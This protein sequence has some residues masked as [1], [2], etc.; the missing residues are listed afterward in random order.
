MY[1]R[2][3]ETPCLWHLWK[4]FFKMRKDL[5][6]ISWKAWKQAIT[7]QH[8]NTP[9]FWRFH[10]AFRNPQPDGYPLD[11]GNKGFRCAEWSPQRWGVLKCWV[12]IACFYAFQQ[13]NTKFFL[14]FV[15]NF[16][17][18]KMYVIC[19]Y[20]CVYVHHAYGVWVAFCCACWVSVPSLPALLSLFSQDGKTLA[21]ELE[22][23]EGMQFERG[24]ISPYFINSPKG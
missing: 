7:T 11:L 19:T 13:I 10:S 24:Y 14:I 2:M 17:F 12:P 23:V 3:Y 18:S 6:M 21:D 20:V 9:H 4:H 5:G 8:F 15:E 22:I 16:L 1:V